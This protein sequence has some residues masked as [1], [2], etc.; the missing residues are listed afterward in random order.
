MSTPDIAEPFLYGGRTIEE[1]L[2]VIVDRVVDRFG[3]ERV[4]LF[5][6]L[7]TGHPGR[8]SDI[9]LLVVFRAPADR[10]STAVALRL[11]VAD[12]P[13]PVDFVVTD[14]AEIE[15]RGDIPGSVLRAALTEGRVVHAS[16]A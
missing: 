3:P 16:A 2:P 14:L 7:A 1:W 5:G 11:A 15:R 13:A 8:D 12:L 4:I 10:R 6:S 9:D